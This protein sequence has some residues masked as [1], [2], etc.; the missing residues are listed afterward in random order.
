MKN[1]MKDNEG[2]ISSMRIVMFAI[3]F[4]ALFIADY[5][6]I[7]NIAH[8]FDLTA[9][10]TLITLALSFKVGQKGI[11]NKQKKDNNE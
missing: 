7:H 5:Q 11:E 4:N 9:A 6:V 2:K 1:L 3:I 8:T 10:A